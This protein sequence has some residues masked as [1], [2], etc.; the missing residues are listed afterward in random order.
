MKLFTHCAYVETEKDMESAHIEIER[1]MEERVT[2]RMLLEAAILGTKMEEL[3]TLLQDDPA[4]LDRVM[5]ECRG[6]DN[7]LHGNV[8]F[9]K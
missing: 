1:D 6:K 3:P 7:P 4:I 8:N 5:R 9:V 2:H